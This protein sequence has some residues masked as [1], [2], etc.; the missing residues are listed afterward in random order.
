MIE[1]LLHPY[2]YFV[3]SWAIIT[4]LLVTLFMI[5]DL[6]IDI[7][8][9][10]FSLKPK[11]ITTKINQAMQS[12]PEKKIAILIANWKEHEVI[13]RMIA[14]NIQNIKYDNYVFFIGVYPNDQLTWDAGRK[15]ENR[16]S[17][18][19]VIVNTHDGPTTKGQMLN[20]MTRKIITLS[21]H[22]PFD[23]FL[24]HDSEDLIH[25]FAFKLINYFSNSYSFLQI[26]VFSLAQKWND[27]TGGI[28]CDEFSEAHCKDMLV[29][30]HLGGGVPSAGVGTAFSIDLVKTLLEKQNGQL[31]RQDCLTED[32]VL[33]LTAHYLKFKSTFLNYYLVINKKKSFIATR[34]YFP[35]NFQAS[36]RQKTRWTTGIAFQGKDILKWQGTLMQKYFLWRDRRGFP[37]AI[38]I[39]SSTLLIPFFLIE[40]INPVFSILTQSQ[41]FIYLTAINLVSM[42]WRLAQRAHYVNFIYGWKFTLGIPVR[43]LLGNLINTVAAIKSFQNYRGFQN[44]GN[45]IKWVK[46]AH[47]LPEN[48]G[49]NLDFETN[50][51]FR[52]LNESTTEAEVV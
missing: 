18:V 5:D 9:L 22:S 32:Y 45:E 21:E 34:E 37:N 13:E 23:L 1:F 7:C 11:P 12:T 28:Y 40:F 49:L 14:G 2:Q 30:N 29:R 43:W 52:P 19:H 47:K 35:D 38:L 44:T 42:I 41:V 17:N 25:P 20:E 16:F 48:F 15:L 36:I 51:K 6:F 3:L 33:G 26:P 10:I 24:M 8:A 31:L 27:W 4:A 39:L 50:E 46:T